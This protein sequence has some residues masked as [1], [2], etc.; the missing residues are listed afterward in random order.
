MMI[1]EAACGTPSTS[2]NWSFGLGRW[3][4]REVAVDW[5][6]LETRKCWV[7]RAHKERRVPVWF[8]NVPDSVAGTSCSQTVDIQWSSAKAFSRSGCLA[9]KQNIGLKSMGG[10]SWLVA[11]AKAQALHGRR[12]FS[13][14]LVG[15]SVDR[16]MCEA[17][18]NSRA[19]APLHAA[20]V[21]IVWTPQMHSPELA[22]SWLSDPR[23]SWRAP[24][25]TRTQR[26][27]GSA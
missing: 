22:L 8:N 27:V 1:D 18:N 21:C 17:L 23:A 2:A 5:D 3:T 4:G 24:R 14:L 16:K 9:A 19:A 11:A 26:V 25:C 13:L 7:K 20:G 10:Y 15:D 12:P 6:K